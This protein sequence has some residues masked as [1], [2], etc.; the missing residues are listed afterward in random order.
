MSMSTREY[1]R[2]NCHDT[3]MELCDVDEACANKYEFTYRTSLAD[4]MNSV[5][6][7]KISSENLK[8]G[9]YV[10]GIRAR[11]L[12][13]S[14]TQAYGLAVAGGGAVLQ[15]MSNNWNHLGIAS[16][17]ATGGVGGTSDNP[18]PDPDNEFSPPET[19]SPTESPVTESASPTSTGE[20]T[21]APM[22]VNSF[23]GAE[24]A[25]SWTQAPQHP[26]APN[27]SDDNKE[28]NED[29]VTGGSSS[30]AT[31]YAA[32]GGDDP[33]DGE[34]TGGNSGSNRDVVGSLDSDS[35]MESTIVIAASVAGAA[36]LIAVATY[37]ALR[38]R[39]GH[40][41]SG[42]T[43]SEMCAHPFISRGAA[44]RISDGDSVVTADD[45]HVATGLDDVA[46]GYGHGN[47]L[48]S[49]AVKLPGYDTAVRMSQ[50][51]EETENAHI[52]RSASTSNGAGGADESGDAG[53]LDD[54]TTEMSGFYAAVDPSAV[55]KLVEWGI[56]RDFARVALRQ[57]ENDIPAALR[58]VAKGDMDTRLALDLEEI[59]RRVGPKVAEGAT[60]SEVATEAK[61]EPPNNQSD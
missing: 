37:I 4:Y 52:I 11:S 30:S 32:V 13:E 40:G 36:A 16:Q 55:S 41:S 46:S 12:T 9:Y 45:G 24:P 35:P 10:I 3:I 22:A 15:D 47:H 20:N 23:D 14:D 29:A 21:A 6:R 7:I 56:G 61:E 60:E 58:M 53:F 26:S 2:S 48:T 34:S 51:Q 5:E 57:T 33:T 49:P 39:K 28:Q 54:A 8:E 42:S 44:A 38:R 1:Y 31:A 19:S 27:T 25:I 17:S 50:R 59:A 43:N 18:E